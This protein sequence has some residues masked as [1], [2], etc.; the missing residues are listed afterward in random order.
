MD[1]TIR[2]TDVRNTENVFGIQKCV[3]SDKYDDYIMKLDH[4]I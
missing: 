3:I 1:K 2:I 4:L